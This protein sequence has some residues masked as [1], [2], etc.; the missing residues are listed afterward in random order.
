MP[1][2]HGFLVPHLPPKHASLDD[3]A[4]ERTRERSSNPQC[5]SP[6]G[7]IPLIHATHHAAPPA[8]ETP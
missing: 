3:G 4:S 2:I 7:C 6:Y 1:Y 8:N 5:S